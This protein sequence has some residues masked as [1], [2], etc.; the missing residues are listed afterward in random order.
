MLVPQMLRER[1]PDARIGFFLHIP[2]PSSDVFRTLPVPR[3]R[4][5]DGLLGAD[6]IGFHTAGYR[7][8]LRVRRRCCVL[9]VSTDVDRV[10]WDDRTVRSASSRWA[11][12]PRSFERA[13]RAARGAR[14]GAR[15]CA[16]RRRRAPAGR[17]RSPRLHEGHPAPAARLR[18]AA[19][20]PPRAARA[21]AP[22]PGGGAV[23]H[24]T[25]TPTRSSATRSTS[26]S[27]GSTAPSARRSWVPI[28]YI[29]PRPAA[30]ARWWRSTAPPTSC[31]SRRCATA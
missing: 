15:R 19:A 8:A 7:A 18:A 26:S 20:R 9:G 1:L 5:C 3:P 30:R 21:G 31:W 25:S 27:A 24:R 2:F 29:Y 11:S 10:R 22:H 23:A 14:R 12:T 17:H 4:C 13:G 6:L 16:R 28:H